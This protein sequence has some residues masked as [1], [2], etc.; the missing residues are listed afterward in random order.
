M[1]GRKDRE[2]L[3]LFITGLLDQ[4]APGDQVLSHAD[5]FLLLG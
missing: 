1:L 2:Q 5:R 4:L 3:D